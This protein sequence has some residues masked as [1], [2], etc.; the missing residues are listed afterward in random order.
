MDVDVQTDE[1]SPQPHHEAMSHGRFQEALDHLQELAD[2]RDLSAAELELLA[3]AAYG[4][5]ALETAVTAWER[6]HAQHI[7]TGQHLMAARAATSVAMYLMMDTGLM[8]PVRGWLSRAE[9]LLEGQDE[10][11][12]HAWLAMTRTYERL[13]SGDLEPARHWAQRAIQVGDRQDAPAP[14]TLGR[15][16]QARVRIIDGHVDEGLARLDDAAVTIMSGG[17]DPLVTGMAYCELICAM[18]GLAQYDRAEQWTDAMERW[19]HDNAFGGINGRCRVHR[20]EILRLRGSC[21]AAE[22]EAR[23]ACDEL[24]P[25]MRREFG[26][27]LTELGVIRLRRGDLTGAEEAFLEAH[28]HGWDPHPGLALL[29]L[30]QGDTAQAATLIGDALDRPVSAPSKER[31]PHTDLQRAPLLEAQVEICLANGDLTTARASGDELARIAEVFRS[32]A[33]TASSVLARARISLVDDDTGA[34]NRQAEAAVAIWCEIGAPYETAVARSVLAQALDRTGNEAAARTERT[35]AHEAL[36]RIGARLPGPEPA[37]SPRDLPQH[38]GAVQPGAS[39]ATERQIFQLEG[40]TRTIVFDGTS[41]LLRDLKGL[42]YLERLLDHPCREFHVLDLVA[43]EEGTGP[44]PVPADAAE[45]PETSDSDA[46]P[47]LDATAK[48][49]YHRRLAEIEDDLDEATRRGDVDRA[50]L[51]SADRDYLVAELSRAVGLGGRTRTAGSTSER[52]RA[53]VTRTLR[54][55]MS[56]ITTHHPS[57]GQ[58]LEQTVRTGTYCSYQPDPRAAGTWRT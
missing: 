47:I 21:Q 54:Y 15:I 57:L 4:A 34:A 43:A 6:L 12:V 32:R 7:A 25:W 1:Q 38:T 35:A 39:A 26:W 3:N 46:G 52:A 37:G 13:L 55:A 33:L 53:S 14:A 9:R 50:A 17:I 45:L 5:G 49:A 19:R 28:Q 48:Q 44:E 11:A 18:Q 42:R 20:A 29:R 31:P 8:A 40:D 30:A 51:A 58:H 10:A 2:E 16:A 36:D 23:H 27:P 41:V 22:D 24:R 56:Q